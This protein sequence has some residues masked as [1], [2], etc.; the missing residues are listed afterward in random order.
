MT[1]RGFAFCML[2]VAACTSDYGGGD[3][4]GTTEPT[5]L[6]NDD[7]VLLDEDQALT[8]LDLAANDV[9]VKNIK[10]ID[11]PL[12]GTIASG[13]YRPEPG[14]FGPD[15]FTYDGRYSQYGSG[16]SRA[17][18]SIGIAS[19]GIGFEHSRLLG[20][21]NAWD[22]AAGDLD[23]DG[24][25][26]LVTVDCNRH[27]MTV[28]RNTTTGEGQ[29][30][31]EAS[32]FEGGALPVELAI[33]DVDGDGK[34]DI[35]TAAIDG[36][37]V[38]RNL[39]APAGPLAFDGP[40]LLATADQTNDVVAT[41]LDGDGKIDLAAVT[42][43]L[44]YNEGHVNVW[45]NG[46]TPGSIAF[47][48]ETVFDAPD[49]A[50]QITEVDADR[51]GRRDL[52]VLGKT[53]LSLFVNATTAGA[54]VP[55]FQARVDRNT[56]PEP[57]RMFLADLDGDNATEIGVLHKGG[58]LWIYAN[59]GTSSPS[60]EAAR[61]IEVPDTIAFVETAE[62][63]GDGVVDL[64]GASNGSAP[65]QFLA[66]RSAPMSFMFEASEAKIADVATHKA[67]GFASPAALVFVD[68]DGI[69][70]LEIVVASRGSSAGEAT[71][72]RVLYGR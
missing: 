47:G 35:I 52:A 21:T 32:V 26:D 61:S 34:K 69:A 10:V 2:A 19:D 28:F 29:Y 71:G 7:H 53:Q 6:A 36:L 39:T 24:K 57:Q 5:P 43:R 65:F 48:V 30:S 38:F 45:L 37:T 13:E 14:Y 4:D 3:D 49:S 8:L 1:K 9:D 67:A 22:V 42:T 55:A 50:W 54:A 51:D 17:T 72:L 68:L 23:G 20:G 40:V 15:H 31:V 60:F 44:Y 46:S 59:R 58:D 25:T 70:P 12:H 63:D 11:P 62:I 56:A 66:N 18:V 64:V 41:D 33:A 16:V 27:E